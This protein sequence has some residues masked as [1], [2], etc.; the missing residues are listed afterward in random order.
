MVGGRWWVVVGGGGGDMEK[1]KPPFPYS[2]GRGVWLL[3]STRWCRRCQRSNRIDGGRAAMGRLPPA[4]PPR[5]VQ[6]ESC[7]FQAVPLPSV[8]A[9][10]RR[11]TGPDRDQAVPLDKHERKV[12]TATQ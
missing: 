3:R 6:K 1:G 11:S 8:T 9:V 12:A 5:R 7:L 2:L 10:L 4:D